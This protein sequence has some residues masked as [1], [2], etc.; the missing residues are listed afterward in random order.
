LRFADSRAQ[1]ARYEQALLQRRGA[2]RSSARMRGLLERLL[3][4]FL[5]VALVASGLL[6]TSAAPVLAGQ[7]P[8]AVIIVGPV[9]GLTSSFLDSARRIAGQAE[10]AGMDVR[11]IYH[12]SAT[13]AKVREAIQGAKL[14]VYIGHGNGWPS[15]YA[16][17]QEKT[18]NGLGLNPRVGAG[19]YEV[20]YKGADH[21]RAKV[22][23]APRAVVVLYRLCYA[24]GNGEAWMKP[25][26]TRSVAV[27]RVDNYA[28]G[29]LAAGAATVFAFGTSQAL[30]LPG[31]LM[32][33]SLSMDEIF[34]T[35]GSSSRSMYDGFQGS[36][37]YYAQSSRTGG[38]RLH[39][40]PHPDR[41]H[42]RAVTGNLELTAS[43]WRG[44][45]AKGGGKNKGGGRKGTDD[46]RKKV[47]DRKK[48][49]TRPKLSGVRVVSSGALDPASLAVPQFS[50]DGDGMGDRLRIAWTLSE[51]AEVT[52]VVR[53]S[54]GRK[55]RT[56]SR[57]AGEGRGSI[58]WNGQT[59]AGRA[60]PDGVYTIEL[61][62]RDRAGNASRPRSVKA[63][64]AT[65]LRAYR[66]TRRTIHA[67]DGD[68]LARRAG[69]RVEVTRRADIT[70]RIQ[71][72]NGRTVR[73]LYRGTARPG[74]L[75]RAWNGRNDRDRYVP[76]GWYTATV[77]AKAGGSR[78]R[79]QQRLWV[80]PFR[81]T[82]SAGT[83]RRGKEITLTL[84]A[85]ETLRK[86]PTVSV[87]QP[88]LAPYELETRKVGS[89]RYQ[90]TFK[91]KPKGKPG[92][93]RLFVVGKDERGGEESTTH[94]IRLS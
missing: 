53:D 56:L 90:V 42:L 28:A 89:G 34:R 21:L 18:K 35:R 19:P 11:R 47:A 32:R 61:V 39:L 46:D 77:V 57:K 8:K 30:D 71:N 62:A 24:A 76:T 65:T 45:V 2:A 66:A 78:V 58:A 67:S 37:D 72:A 14:V 69:L 68:R 36:D 13:W 20:E 50:P 94:S 81:V 79:Y 88:G 51:K 60:A 31:L 86:P 44:E 93:M 64:V 73:T 22:R 25:E 16:P 92:T 54:E 38:A 26:R 91:P 33:S 48:D 23:L 7:R 5:A 49:R 4:T 3:V 6:S 82:T 84:V 1:G 63:K 40:D 43:A 9:G 17:Y 75:K 41:G 85:T 87:K 29:F 52:A 83:A 12:P 10:T 74:T 70:W 80:G 55:R 59:A 27:E 15:P